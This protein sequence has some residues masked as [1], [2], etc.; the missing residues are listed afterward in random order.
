MR[1]NLHHSNFDLIDIRRTI[2]LILSGI[3][4]N[5]FIQHGVV[6]VAKLVH[7]QTDSEL[8]RSVNDCDIINI[9]GMG[10]VWARAFWVTRCLNVLQVL[11]CSMP[12]WP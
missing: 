3:E 7:M 12:F 1:I 11:I 4:S 8:R 2:D 10:V 9:D 5:Q 6:N